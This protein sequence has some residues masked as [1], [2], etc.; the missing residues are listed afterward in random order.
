MKHIAIVAALLAV[1]GEATAQEAVVYGPPAPQAR[2]LRSWDV[3]AGG[4][5][6][7]D[8]AHATFGFSRLHLAYHR[9]LSED[10]TV[11]GSVAFDYA[12]WAPAD[13]FGSAFTV[14]AP[15]RW[16]AYH[17]DRLSIGLY[18]EPA[19]YFGFSQPRFS[20]FI[21]GLGVNVGGNAGWR[22]YEWL[23]VGVGL[24]VPLLFGLPTDGRDA[25]VAMPVLVGPTAELYL[26]DDWAFTGEAKIGPHVVSDDFFGTRF[27]LRLVAGIAKRFP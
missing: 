26:G 23:Q 10:L 22:L 16:S 6:R 18:G 2:T 27:G 17:R 3:L 21:A 19:L 7:G 5:Q 9:A 20:Q 14:G 11:G 1:T 12:H 25:F 15:V 4:V 13:S 24:D 8:L